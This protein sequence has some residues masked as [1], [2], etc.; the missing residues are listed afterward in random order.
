MW[1]PD[2]ARLVKVRLHNRG[3]DVETPWAEDLG[4]LEGPH[5]GRLVRIG[6]VPFL[7]AKPT[8]GDVIAVIPDPVDGVL[9]WDAAGVAFDE[10]GTRIE[11]DG[12]RWVT[13]IDYWPRSPYAG[14]DTVFKA[15]DVAGE[16]IDVAVEGA[17]VRQGAQT[18]RAYLAV[19]AVMTLQDVL[20]WLR[21]GVNGLEFTLVHPVDDA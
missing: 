11:R 13:I 16:E 8:Y 3:E 6:N 7:R 5:A 4:P 2:K 1:L 14:L 19:P 12:G 21:T 15:L 17:F 9:V 18:A 20:D 10:I